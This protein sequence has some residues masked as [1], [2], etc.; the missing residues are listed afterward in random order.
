MNSICR[1]VTINSASA[2]KV[3]CQRSY[4]DLEKKIGL[5]H[6]LSARRFDYYLCDHRIHSSAMRAIHDKDR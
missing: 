6:A 1:W 3:I 4:E 5:L 2:G